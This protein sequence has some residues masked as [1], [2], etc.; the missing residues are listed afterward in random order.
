MASSPMRAL[1]LTRARSSHGCQYWLRPGTTWAGPS[2][3]KARRGHGSGSPKATSRRPSSQ[4]STRSERSS[5]VNAS[6]ARRSRRRGEAQASGSV[7]ER[8]APPGCAASE[9]IAHGRPCASRLMARMATTTAPVRGCVKRQ[10][11]PSMPTP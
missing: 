11:W 4:R 1:P 6:P 7:A 9:A 10:K 3:P 8:T 2:A 5:A